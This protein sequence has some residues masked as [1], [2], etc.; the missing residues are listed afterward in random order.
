VEE[1]S[2]VHLSEQWRVYSPKEK[3]VGEECGRNR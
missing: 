3:N 1:L 2:T